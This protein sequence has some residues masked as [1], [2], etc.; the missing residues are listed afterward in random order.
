MDKWNDLVEALGH[1]EVDGDGNE[2]IAIDGIEID[3]RLTTGKLLSMLIE[4][5]LDYSGIRVA[6]LGMRK[7]NGALSEKI[8]YMLRLIVTMLFENPAYQIHPDYQRFP[9]SLK[10]VVEYQIERFKERAMQEQ[11]VQTSEPVKDFEEGK[12][13]KAAK[14]KAKDIKQ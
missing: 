12:P 3:P 13:Q 2:L 5:D 11:S 10:K 14:D 6:L 4:R 7:Q 1:D 9:D 8:G